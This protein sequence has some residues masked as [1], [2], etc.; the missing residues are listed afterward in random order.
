[1]DE[2]LLSAP[3]RDRLESIRHP[4]TRLHFVL[5]RVALRSLLADRLGI[6]PED[7]PL[8]MAPGGGIDLAGGLLHVSIA[9]AGEQA[10]AVAAPR[11]IGVDLEQVQARSP[12]VVDFML[13]T[14]ERAA[15][16]ALPLDPVRR[17]ILYWTLKESVLKAMRTGLRRSP[18]AVRLV[19]SVPEGCGQAVVEGQQTFEL[20]FQERDGYCLSVAYKGLA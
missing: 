4:R 15:Y 14:D 8:I 2:T 7:V 3:E 19:V 10:V 12:G 13:H 20:W 11:A 18:K 6:R 9:H 17:L 16:D 5:G 1:M